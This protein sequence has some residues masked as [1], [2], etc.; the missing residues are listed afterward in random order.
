MPQA[1]RSRTTGRAL[2]IRPHP[3][4][5]AGERPGGPVAKRAG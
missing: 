3:G 1:M 4:L 2:I 5:H